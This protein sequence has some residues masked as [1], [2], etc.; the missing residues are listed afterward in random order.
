MFDNYLTI[1]PED[2]FGYEED[3][4]AQRKEQEEWKASHPMEVDTELIEIYKEFCA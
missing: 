2:W 3:M 1:T 4:A